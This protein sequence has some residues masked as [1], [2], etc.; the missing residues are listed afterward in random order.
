MLTLSRKIGESLRIG[1]DVRVVVR[2]VRG[3]QVQLSIEAPAEVGVHR[4]EVYEAI[5]HANLAAAKNQPV[6]PEK[7]SDDSAPRQSGKKGGV[8]MKVQTSRFGEIEI[9][10]EKVVQFP[11]GLLGLHRFQRYVFIDRE[12]S[13]LRWMQSMDLPELA[14]LVADP[15]VFAPDYKAEVRVGELEALGASD[16]RSLAVAVICTVTDDPGD[17]T[18]NLKAPLI[19]DV[20]KRTAKQVVLNESPYSIHHPWSMPAAA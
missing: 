10:E 19:I 18:V 4:E 9:P 20:E 1:P 15:H 11:E 3:Q 7:D 5:R 6:E 12:N 16:P 13:P 17:A 14:F 8:V 2:A